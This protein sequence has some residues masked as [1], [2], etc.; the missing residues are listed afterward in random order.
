MSNFAEA[1]R[2]FHRG[3][4][5]RIQLLSE[6]DRQLNEYRTTPNSLLAT[7][8]EEHGAAKLPLEVYQEIAQRISSF[9]WDYTIV[10]AVPAA[11]EI[12]L[13]RHF[14]QQK[15]ELLRK[16]DDVGNPVS[17]SPHEPPP[18]L[19]GRFKLI[20]LVGEGGMS[21]VYKA[22]DLR[23]VE[24]RSEDP[25]VAVKV[26]T[27]LFNDD[28]GSLAVLHREAHKLQSLTHPNIVRVID[29]DRDGRT[30]FMTMEFLS[31]EPL[32]SRIAR[33]GL[34]G[35]TQE[36]ALPIIAGIAEALEFAHRKFIVHADLKPGNVIITDNGET[37]VIDFGI[38]RFLGKAKE[39]TG[40]QDRAW[41]TPPALTP[42]YASPEMLENKEADPRDDV[43][44]LCCISYE[45]LTG[46]HPFA[47]QSATAARQ[48]GLRPVRL[49]GLSGRQFKAIAAGLQFDRSKR[50]ASARQFLDQFQGKKSQ[51]RRRV[52]AAAVTVAALVGG[53]LYQS[54][55][56]IEVDQPQASAPLSAGTVFRDCPTCPLMTVLPSGTFVQG[57]SVTAFEQPQHTVSIAYPLAIAANEVTIREFSEFVDDTGVVVEGCFAYDGEWTSRADVSWNSVDAAHTGLHP[58]SCV[59]WNDATAYVDWLSKKTSETY[60]LPSASEWEYAA[61]AATQASETLTD[62]D[63]CKRANVADRTA[64][65]RYPGWDVL[66]CEDRYVQAAPVGSFAPNAFGLRDTLGNVFEWVTDCWVDDYKGAPGDGSAR[67]ADQCSEHE[68]RGGSWFTSPQYLRPT[69]RN[70]FASDYR[71]TAIGFRVVRE[72]DR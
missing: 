1:L 29:C 37:K 63:A 9:M 65:A 31:G 26:L 66:D 10:P 3:S 15:T 28:S 64:A 60:R 6:V 41:E 12:N 7:L 24:A 71:S 16:P 56:P 21:R 27:A 13:P 34:N 5:S 39:A 11:V 40:D 52:L 70:R 57:S 62:L 72:L 36:E 14:D 47:R 49:P 22:I 51:R 2:T 19:Q 18:L 69:Y 53:I 61:R 33:R 54:Y 67:L 4:M 17:A 38:A 59:S 42:P 30:V 68:L 48:L 43:Y 44:A 25:Y 20:Q 55:K 46:K 58:V 8:D 32:Q 45:V 50:T 23:R 35:L